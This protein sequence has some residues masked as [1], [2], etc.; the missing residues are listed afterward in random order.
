MTT[1]NN[2]NQAEKPFN[3]DSIMIK[4]S[5]SS[6]KQGNVSKFNSYKKLENEYDSDFSEYS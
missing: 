6:S 4:K 2:N 3:V 1:N 5:L